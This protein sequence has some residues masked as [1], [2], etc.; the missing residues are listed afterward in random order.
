MKLAV[1]SASLAATEETTTERRTLGEVLADGTLGTDEE[2]SFHRSERSSPHAPRHPSPELQLGTLSPTP[3]QVAVS[4]SPIVGPQPSLGQAV[5]PGAPSGTRTSEWAMVE[6]LLARPEHRP[7]MREVPRLSTENEARLITIYRQ[8]GGPWSKQHIA[9]MLAFGGGSAAAQ[10]FRETL[11]KTYAGKSIAPEDDL[12]LGYM[13]QLCGVLAHRNDDALG[14]LLEASRAEFW[15]AQRLWM[16]DRRRVSAGILT[17][18]SIN[19]LGLSARQEARELLDWY[20]NHPQEVWVTERDVTSSALD[21][22]V[23][24]AAFNMNVVQDLGIE[25]AMDEVF[26]DPDRMLSRFR[27]WRK[28]PEG[29]AWCTWAMRS[30]DLARR[31]K[32]R[33]HDPIES[34]I[35]Q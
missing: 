11:T 20:R 25:A 27:V 33:N 1:L 22:S 12:I 35:E 16:A 8:G 2:V 24:E 15:L 29:V 13:P 10:V 6:A 21:G 7:L 14:F 4:N 31:P 28:T 17:G 3:G 9:R 18:A 30:S 34:A 19:G 5:P 32:V 26:Y 23:V